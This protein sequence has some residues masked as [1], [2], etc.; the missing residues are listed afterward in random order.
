M[1]AY[2]NDTTT[3]RFICW[4]NTEVV[5]TLFYS[6]FSLLLNTYICVADTGDQGTGTPAIQGLGKFLVP[7]LAVMCSLCSK[8]KNLLGL[9]I[10]LYANSYFPKRR[11][12]QMNY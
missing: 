4:V 8:F 2:W 10:L 12:H 7:V 9:S 5:V 11:V 6:T 3:S 1:P